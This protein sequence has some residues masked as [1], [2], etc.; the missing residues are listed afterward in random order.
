MEVHQQNVKFDLIGCRTHQSAHFNC[1]QTVF[2]EV[3]DAN[4]NVVFSTILLR[5]SELAMVSCGEFL[6]G[7]KG[8]SSFSLKRAFVYRMCYMRSG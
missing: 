4:F 7:L 1:A 3:C 2:L 5:H 8:Q 6:R